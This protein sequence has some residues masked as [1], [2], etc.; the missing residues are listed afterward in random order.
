M[1]DWQLIS[2]IIVIFFI[3]YGVPMILAAIFIR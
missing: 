3:I 1:K 2:G